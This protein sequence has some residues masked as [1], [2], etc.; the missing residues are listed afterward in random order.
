MRCGAEMSAD[1]PSTKDRAW[2][3]DGLL[4]R[5]RAARPLSP[6]SD[7]G[8]ISHLV[9][10]I[11]ESWWDLDAH[12]GRRY[13]EYFAKDGIFDFAGRTQRGRETIRE[14]FAQR[15]EAGARM[16]IHILSNFVGKVKND[17]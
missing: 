2:P 3:A 14:H 5:P 1:V 8:L 11:V 9:E 13:H 17:G 12:G 10:L 7:G 6:I 16:T 15:L 4:D